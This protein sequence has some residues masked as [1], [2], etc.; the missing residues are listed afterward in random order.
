MTLPFAFANDEVGT[1]II[2]IAAGKAPV[3]LLQQSGASGEVS[4][5]DLRSAAQRFV[6][7]VM[8]ATGSDLFTVLGVSSASEPVAS[9]CADR[10]G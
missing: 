4:I 3:D 5:D 7:K 8:L 9:A 2:Q 1:A 10:A 6:A